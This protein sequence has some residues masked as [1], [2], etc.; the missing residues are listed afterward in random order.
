MTF[1]RDDMVTVDDVIKEE[2]MVE[3]TTFDDTIFAFPIVVD[4]L[5]MFVFANG[6]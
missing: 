1:V 5:F 2:L 3:E 4:R 6:I